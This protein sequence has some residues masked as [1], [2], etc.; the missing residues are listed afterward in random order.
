M[1]KT[2]KIWYIKPPKPGLQCELSKSLGISPLTA[3]LLINRGI[4]DYD[5]AKKF[6]DASMSNLSNPKDISGIKAAAQRLVE[7]VK[8]DEKILIYGDYDVDGLT[9]TAIM[10]EYFQQIG[11]EVK[12]LIPNR[13]ENGYGLSV[14][15]VDLILEKDC[16]LVLTVDCGINSIKEVEL[17]KE[18]GI[19]VIITDHHLPEGD[20]PNATAVV[21]PKLASP[22]DAFHLAG[23]GVAFKVLQV[24]AEEFNNSHVLINSLD[25]VA[26]GTVADIVPLFGDNRILVKEGLEIINKTNRP[27]LK[28]LISISGFSECNLCTQELSFGLAPRLNAA[29]RIGDCGLALELLLTKSLQRADELAKELNRANQE[30]QLIESSITEQVEEMV[31]NEID[32]EKEKII[33]LASELWHLGVVG[34]V[35]SRI[36]KKFYRPVILIAIEGEVGRGSARSIK[37]CNIFEGLK[38]CAHLLKDFGGHEQAAGIFI[39]T[40]NIQAFKESINKWADDN[41]TQ[42]CFIPKVYGEAEVVM[43]ELDK[44]LVNELNSLAPFG[45]GNPNPILMC[46]GLEVLSSR[47]VGRQENHLKILLASETENID[48]IG[49]KLGFLDEIAAA[50]EKLD[51]AFYLENNKWNGME[52]LQ[53]N[54]KDL[55]TSYPNISFCLEENIGENHIEHLGERTAYLRKVEKN[56]FAGTS[57]DVLYDIKQDITNFFM[58]ENNHKLFIVSET[59]AFNSILYN[60]FKSYLVYKNINSICISTCLSN[61]EI[62]RKLAGFQGIIFVSKVWWEFNYKNLDNKL[63]Q[64]V[65][66]TAKNDVADMFLK[67]YIIEQIVPGELGVS[68]FKANM[69]NINNLK[70]LL[71]DP[72]LILVRDQEQQNNI[73]Q[74]LKSIMPLKQISLWHENLSYLKQNEMIEKFNKGIT[75]VF[76]T[77]Y[78]IPRGVISCKAQDIFLSIPLD[79]LHWNFLMM[80]SKSNIIYLKEENVDFSNMLK[81]IYPTRECLK[82]VY[83][84]ARQHKKRISELPFYLIKTSLKKLTLN[85]TENACS[86]IINIFSELGLAGTEEDQWVQLENSWRYMENIQQHNFVRELFNA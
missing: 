81:G 52:K 62:E 44:G 72:A 36:A 5:A 68:K 41:L 67:N 49:F 20:I 21:N 1:R 35:A 14:D 30:R 83:S 43:S 32:I 24:L 37:G 85:V 28:A 74:K 17:L 33:V 66:V 76:L 63:Y 48:A 31:L 71:N 27:G 65:Y 79:I 82:I 86:S 19:D 3:Q 6:L 2:R 47:K 69:D 12:H 59:P 60:Y 45:E 56:A 7:A 57:L 18:K 40:N 78:C 38:N 26:L 50:G 64:A 58:E 15:M 42:D 10:M 46:R 11:V 39:D 75:K 54:I 84:L 70:R 23:V 53:L 51:L 55:K 77:T 13:L 8:N 9:S 4:K 22:E 80:S 25:L 29:G 73:L 34:I 61:E 16:S